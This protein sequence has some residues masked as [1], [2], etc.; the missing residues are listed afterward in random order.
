MTIY[1]KAC[2]HGKAC[3]DMGTEILVELETEHA[4][5]IRELKNS[6]RETSRK[7]NWQVISHDSVVVVLRRVVVE[8][9]STCQRNR[10]SRP[11]DLN[12]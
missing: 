12:S 5:E 9:S 8:N 4:I 10:M 3:R 6:V 1:V 2:F 7:T 11:M